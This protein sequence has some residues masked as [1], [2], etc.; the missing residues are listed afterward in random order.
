MIFKRHEAKYQLTL[1]QLTLLKKEFEQYMVAD[2]HGEN[3]I[4]SLYYD[5]PDYRLIRRSIEKPVYKEKLRVRSYGLAQADSAVFV[6]LKKKYK[7]VVYK[8][9]IS[10]TEKEAMQYLST[11][12]IS[13]HSQITN[14]IDYFM[15]YYEGLA[16]S[17]LLSYKREAYYGKDDHDFRVT[18]DR[19]VLWRDYNLSLSD[20]I[21][22]RPL[23]DSNTVLMEVKT[24]EAIPLWMV[25]FLSDNHIY[26]TSF[27]KYGTAYRTLLEEKHKSE[28]IIEIFHQQNLKQEGIF[29]YA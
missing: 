16:P 2:V 1:E 20:G 3:T 9:R 18:F 17:M 25:K 27:S 13:E 28:E 7:K 22:G 15:K 6:E 5:T 8:R 14:E 11:G 21:Y 19:D 26:K 12:E 23:L 29:N 24:A 4:C 10:L